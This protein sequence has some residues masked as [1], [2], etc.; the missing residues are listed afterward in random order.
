MIRIPQ[1]LVIVA[2]GIFPTLSGFKV[3]TSNRHF[4]L[5]ELFMGHV[6][7]ETVTSTSALAA[8]NLRQPSTSYND[9]FRLLMMC[10]F[11][12]F[13][14]TLLENDNTTPKLSVE[15]CCIRSSSLNY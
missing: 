15:G 4:P 14:K 10:S 3:A 5:R 9:V 8:F 12:R 13:E 1:A 6:L 2:T 11:S 7:A